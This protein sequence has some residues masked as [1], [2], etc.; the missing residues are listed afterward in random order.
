MKVLLAEYTAARDPALAPEGKAMLDVLTKSFTACGY[1]VV[2]PDPGDFYEELVRLAPACDMGLVIAPDALLSRFSLPIE[3]HCHTLGC[4]S[5]NV[6]VCANKRST[7]KILRAHGVPVPPPA[8]VGGKHI[9][10]PV[11]GCDAQ[12]VRLTED[13]P[14]N[15][16]F[17]QA[18]IEGELYSV[19]LL[20]NRVVGE[21]CLYFSGNPPVVLAINRQD[22]V[23]NDDGTFTYLGGETPVHPAREQEIIETAKKA[24]TVLGCQGYC[25]IDV[26]VADKVYV[27][28][29]NP[30]I[31]TS[32]VGIA[33]CMDEE[34][35]QLIV[36]T[37]EG[38]AP[39]E[40]HFHGKVRFD[41]FG[42][43]TPV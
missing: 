36:S 21:A 7:E 30:R 3:Q 16:E 4:G 22:V 13:A 9:V 14:G 1:E 43:V 27:L 31:T 40:V 11:T 15:G 42:K 35:A 26:I 25:G 18:Y 20:V 33:A 6:A 8:P 28:D 24:A 34:I 19:S 23:A 12:G 29:V 37:S 39:E 38:V 5:M 32:I 41:R 2:L 17:S 10:K